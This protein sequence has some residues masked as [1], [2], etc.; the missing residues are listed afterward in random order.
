MKHISNFS[1]VMMANLRAENGGC[2]YI[3]L[4]QN[5]RELNNTFNSDPYY[6]NNLNLTSCVADNDGGA[7]NIRNV[8]RIKLD[9]E[10]T[11]LYNSYAFHSGGGI[12]FDCDNYDIDDCQLELGPIRIIN[13]TAKV[14]GGGIY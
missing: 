5:L 9:G 14:N 8:R 4:E 1:D 3:E 12:N 13:N 6:F 10:R 2:I 11:L 7:I